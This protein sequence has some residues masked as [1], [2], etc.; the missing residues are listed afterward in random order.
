MHFPLENI[1]F[2]SSRTMPVYKVRRVAL[3]CD[4]CDVDVCMKSLSCA[5]LYCLS[6]A[7]AQDERI[8]PV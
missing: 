7:G 6:H 3:G 5:F 4:A 1:W 2:V 8:R